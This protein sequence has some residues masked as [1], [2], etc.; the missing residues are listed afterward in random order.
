[1]PSPSPGMNLFLERND[2]W[3]S[4]ANKTAGSARV[5]YMVKRRQVLSSPIHLVE[6]DLRRGGICPSPPELPPCDYYRH[7]M[8]SRRA[9]YNS[10]VAFSLS[11]ST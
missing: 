5:D 11:A 8:S 7:A 9:Y 10:S 6:I 1:M 2:A 3:L 4:P